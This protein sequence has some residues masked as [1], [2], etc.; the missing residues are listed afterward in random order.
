[1]ATKI[2]GVARVPCGLGQKIFLH[3][4]LQNLLS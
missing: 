2:N 1:M 3:P 4:R